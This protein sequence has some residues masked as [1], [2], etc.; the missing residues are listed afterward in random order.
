VNRFPRGP[1][2]T[3]PALS[4]AEYTRN[5]ALLRRACA[6]NRAPCARCRG[7][8]DYDGPRYLLVNG[9][10]RLN[11]RSF[12]A[13]HIVARAHHPDHSL[14]NLQPEC[15]RCSWTSGARLGNQRQKR[16]KTSQPTIPRPATANR[17]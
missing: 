5:R 4:G 7:A 9:K 16:G 13:G 3:D 15:A 12:V 17:W 10:R 14:S 6:A 2:T 1:G 8:I 11:P